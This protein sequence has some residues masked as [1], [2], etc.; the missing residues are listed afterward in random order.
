MQIDM[1]EVGKRAMYMLID[2]I[3]N[4]L[5]EKSYRFDAKLIERNSTV[6]RG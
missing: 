3:N 6:D 2:L 5:V 4:D 1:Q